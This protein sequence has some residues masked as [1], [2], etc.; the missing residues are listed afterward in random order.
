M[1]LFDKIAIF[2]NKELSFKQQKE[3]I[4]EIF[5]SLK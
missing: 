3:R 5:R 2:A 1:K 4:Y